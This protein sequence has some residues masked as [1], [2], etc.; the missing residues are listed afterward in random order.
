MKVMLLELLEATVVA[1]FAVVVINGV[2]GALVPGPGGMIGK[3]AVLEEG[4]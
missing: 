4:G 2:V 1:M 3:V